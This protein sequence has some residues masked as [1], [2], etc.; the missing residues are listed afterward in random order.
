MVA[1][2][3][4]PLVAVD[5]SILKMLYGRPIIDRVT[6]KSQFQI[7]TANCYALSFCRIVNIRLTIQKYSLH[8][9][10]ILRPA[11]VQRQ[12]V[13]PRHSAAS[14]YASSH[15]IPLLFRSSRRVDLHVFLNLPLPLLPSV[16]SS[17]L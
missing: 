6:Y 12:Q 2:L 3:N 17:P 7:I 15:G 5:K 11:L 13:S 14:I 4:V 10:D 1:N 16:G 8:C 9:F